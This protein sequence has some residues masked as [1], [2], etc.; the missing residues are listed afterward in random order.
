MERIKIFF[1]RLICRHNY[2]FKYNYFKTF[3]GTAYYYESYQ[4]KKCD[5]K[6]EV[7]M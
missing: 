2:E 7:K 4:C 3:R 6:K 5:R 1:N